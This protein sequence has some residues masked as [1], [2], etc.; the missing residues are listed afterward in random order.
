[1]AI[2]MEPLRLNSDLDSESH[3][4]YLWEVPGMQVS[5]HLHYDVVDRLL[6]EVMR[7]FGSVPRRGAEVGGLLLGTSELAEK[8]TVRIEDYEPVPCSYMSGPS[9]QLSE[10]DLH[11]FADSCD[12]WRN[13]PDRR[14]YAVGYYR[15]HTR[16][17]LSVT[18]EDLSLLKR[19][20]PPPK[21]V[22]LV[23]KPFATKVSIAGF[24]FW[25]DG[26]MQTESTYLEF[27][28][29]RKELGGGV[30]GVGRLAGTKSSDA[31]GSDEQEP[32]LADPADTDAEKL[33]E[34]QASAAKPESFARKGWVWIPL[35]FIFL[36]LGVLLGF[37]AALSLQKKP[38]GDSTLNPYSLAL[39]VA[40]SGDSLNIRWDRQAPAIRGAKRG[41]LQIDD[42]AYHKQLELDPSQ[43]Q[44]G[45]VIYRRVSGNVTFKL[46][47]FTHDRTSVVETWDYKDPSIAGEVK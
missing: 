38:L 1:M 5:I 10:R 33:Q 27:P 29:R 13:G 19:F 8:L 7:G 17:G 28:F 41:V 22:A 46:E 31:F 44:I 25:E 43:L 26:S 4:S 47:V 39:S 15:S 6:M 40:K 45:S 16:D 42:G 34:M 37:Q 24:F 21:N 32:G 35:S 23:I 3:G 2:E 11:E 18:P 12:R 20:L 14:I 36:F 30:T 9:Y